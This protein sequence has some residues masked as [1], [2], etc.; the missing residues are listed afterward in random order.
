MTAT[1]TDTAI[2]TQEC[3]IFCHH[4]LSYQPSEAI[5]ASYIAGQKGMPS[6][7][8]DRNALDEFLL[9]LGRRGGVLLR[10]ADAYSRLARPA[11]LLRRKLILVIAI[12][13][14]SHQSGRIIHADSS[15]TVGRALLRV[16]FA[17][18][19][20]V[21]WTVAAIIFLGPIHLIRFRSATRHG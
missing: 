4:L 2:L 11:T 9:R 14:T 10:L 3:D 6:G 16:A 8:D 19:S 12:L 18:L 13:E 5:R 7:P 20:S 1:L 15:A 21:G 17:G